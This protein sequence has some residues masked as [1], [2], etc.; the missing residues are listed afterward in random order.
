MKS[1]RHNIGPET[2]WKWPMSGPEMRSPQI[3]ANCAP[4]TGHLVWRAGV[5][6]VAPYNPGQGMGLSIKNLFYNYEDGGW[7][8]IDLKHLGGY[9]IWAPEM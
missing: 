7:L 2:P 5:E 3:G 1:G 4:K 8:K 9:P 6:I